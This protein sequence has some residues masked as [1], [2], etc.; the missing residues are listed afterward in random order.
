MNGAKLILSVGICLGVASALASGCGSSSGGPEPA[1]SSMSPDVHVTEAGADSASLSCNPIALQLCPQ[2]QTCCFAGLR[3]TCTD[4]GSCNTPFRIGCANA[5]SCGSGEVCCGSVQ[6]PQGFDA[7]A[8]GDASFDGSA[9]DASAFDA[10]AFVV[11]LSCASSCPPY[12]FQ[13]CMTDDDCAAGFVCG[14]G[15]MPNGP[16]FGLILPCVP[17]D[18]GF[19]PPDGA[20]DAGTP[21][22]DAG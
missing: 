14:G 3:G 18:A 2:G 10:S 5:A 16:N 7:S 15:P 12:E 13:A 4:I 1:D 21:D 6:L 9:F 11:T 19:P 22:G 17:A 20:P 8:F